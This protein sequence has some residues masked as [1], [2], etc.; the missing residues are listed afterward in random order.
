MGKWRTRRA[1]HTCTHKD[2][3]VASGIYWNYPFKAL[4]SLLE[5]RK[6]RCGKSDFHIYIHERECQHIWTVTWV[7][8][9]FIKPCN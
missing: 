8:G 5:E 2:M 3:K 6:F 1:S 7:P 9:S 4:L